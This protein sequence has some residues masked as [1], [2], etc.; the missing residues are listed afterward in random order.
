M[1]NATL[2]R[3]Y[4]ELRERVK[5]QLA[6]ALK[7]GHLELEELAAILFVLDKAEGQEELALFVEIFSE[8]F[9]V[10]KQIEVEN[11]SAVRGDFEKQVKEIVSKL[12]KKDPLLATEIA[13]EALKPGMDLETLKKKYPQIG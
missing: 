12:I 8:A 9:P 11:R 5:K 6:Y 13:K 7:T 3:A 1:I 4:V 10:L 2:D